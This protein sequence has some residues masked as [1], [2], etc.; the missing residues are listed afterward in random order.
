MPARFS[1]RLFQDLSRH[2]T[3][4]S[5]ALVHRATAEALRAALRTALSAADYARV[6]PVVTEYEGDRQE[7]LACVLCRVALTVSFA[8]ALAKAAPAAGVA[9]GQLGFLVEGVELPVEAV[10]EVLVEAVVDVI[11]AATGAVDM[12]ISELLLPELV[13]AE[14]VGDVGVDAATAAVTELARRLVRDAV[15]QAVGAATAQVQAHLQL[16]GI[17]RD[18]CRRLGTCGRCL[19]QVKAIF[20]T[21]YSTPTF[22]RSAFSTADR[23]AAWIQQAESEVALMPDMP[24]LDPAAVLDVARAMTRGRLTVGGLQLRHVVPYSDIAGTLRVATSETIRAACGDEY[25]RRVRAQITALVNL[26]V[27]D[28]ATRLAWSGVVNQQGILQTQAGR[29][30]ISAVYRALAHGPRNLF[31]AG[32]SANMAIGNRLDVARDAQGILPETMV[33]L[34]EWWWRTMT[35]LGLSPRYQMEEVPVASTGG[36]RHRPVSVPLYSH[37]LSRPLDAVSGDPA[38][39]VMIDLPSAGRAKRRK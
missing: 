17:V 32:G 18:L 34:G 5:N 36:K 3:D 31:H 13:A 6:D 24:P 21:A 33:A 20:S 1:R 25:V 19:E 23:E 16:D 37:A 15:E 12:G 27:E 9:A 26:I 38:E 35:L 39:L 2:L 29:D 10:V 14:A 22:Q 8:Q 11:V 4:S 28:P 30:A 7:C